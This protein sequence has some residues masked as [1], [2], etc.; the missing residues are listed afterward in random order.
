MNT[1]T[2]AVQLSYCKIKG[3]TYNLTK[4]Q[5]IDEHFMEGET[6]YPNILKASREAGIVFCLLLKRPLGT[7]TYHAYEYNSG[8]IKLID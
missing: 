1:E 8:Y 7:R 6:Q 2:L 5:T 4:K 3:I